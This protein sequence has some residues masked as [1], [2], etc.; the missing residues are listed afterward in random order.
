VPKSQLYGLA[1]EM[2]M[3]SDDLDRASEILGVTR[4][5]DDG[6]EM[7]SIVT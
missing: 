7:W 1:I 6:A 3:E 2:L 4:T 5:I